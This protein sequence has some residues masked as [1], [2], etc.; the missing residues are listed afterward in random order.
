MIEIIL[1]SLKTRTSFNR[2]NIPKNEELSDPNINPAKVSKGIV[3]SKSIQNLPFK[4]AIA[5]SFGSIIS[6]PVFE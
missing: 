6:L 5:M 1:F 3:A 2:E 4:Y